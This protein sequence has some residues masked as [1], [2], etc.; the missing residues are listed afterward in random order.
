MREPTDYGDIM[1]GHANGILAQVFGAD[2]GKLPDEDARL[3][4]V[5]FL[6]AANGEGLG[7]REYARRIGSGNLQAY[8]DTMQARARKGW[9]S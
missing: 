7:A 5:D 3:V 1:I 2:W 6:D 9:Q 8:A 4:C